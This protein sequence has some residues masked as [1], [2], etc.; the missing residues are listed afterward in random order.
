VLLTTVTVS[1]A[2]TYGLLSFSG[3][4]MLKQYTP[5]GEAVLWRSGPQKQR[6]EASH[7][8][9]G[10]DAVGKASTGPGLR[11]RVSFRALGS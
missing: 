1:R 3:M 8:A 7:R 10:D 5:S 6:S 2:G 9:Q 4:R 11:L